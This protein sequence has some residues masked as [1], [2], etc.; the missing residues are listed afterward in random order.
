MTYK[1]HESNMDTLQ[2]KLNSFAKKCEKYN[3]PFNFE[4]IGEKFEKHEG[5]ISKFYVVEISGAYKIKGWEL[6]A[7]LELTDYGNQIFKLKEVELPSRF[8]SDYPTCEHC[9]IKRYRKHFGILYSQAEGFKIV[10]KSCL[11]DFLGQDIEL[12]AA[13]LNMMKAAENSKNYDHDYSHTY[14]NVHEYLEA[15]CDIVD[16]YGFVSKTANSPYSTAMMAYGLICP[17]KCSYDIRSRLYYDNT[18][19]TGKH[20]KE[21]DDMIKYIS[22]QESLTDYIHNLKIAASMKYADKKQFGFLASLVPHYRRHLKYKNRE[23][24]NPLKCEFYGRV[25]DRITIKNASISCAF[26]GVNNYGQYFVYQIVDENHIFMWRTNQ[27]YSTDTISL[28]GNIKDHRQ[29]KEQKQTWIT[30][31]RVQ[32]E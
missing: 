6:V 5:A 25:N 22:E 7:M 30:R 29:Y 17:D 31:C 10:G 26:S 20:E 4:V 19:F 14:I 16:K 13:Y 11:N 8:Y 28:T 27:E 24:S 21:V 18:F 1:I 9:G 3:T 23:K 15:V 12:F 2:K 32:K